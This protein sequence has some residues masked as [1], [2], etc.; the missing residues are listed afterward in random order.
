MKRKS[1]P[2]QHFNFL[3]NQ[4]GAT[5]VE[6]ALIALPFFVLVMAIIEFSLYFWKASVVDN[7][8]LQ[9]HRE[10]RMGQVDGS[11]YRQYFCD[12]IG[13]LIGCDEDNLKLN[14]QS[15]TASAP[16]TVNNLVNAYSVN[17]NN[18]FVIRVHYQHDFLL[19]GFENLLPEQ[20]LNT[21][22]VFYGQQ[23]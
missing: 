4:D 21:T 12:N 16:N 17:A 18:P 7:A 15:L 22:I 10:V 14:V 2:N 19:F 11:T 9:L 23:E 3:R 1:S 5:A 6:F 13:G 20:F 8:A